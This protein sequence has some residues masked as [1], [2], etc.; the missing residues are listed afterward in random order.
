MRS[1]CVRAVAC[2][3]ALILGSLG[4]TTYAATNRCSGPITLG[5]TISETGAFSSQT[6][7]WKQMTLAFQKAINRKGGVEVKACHKK[8]PIK[9]VVYNDQS[10]ASTAVSLFEKMATGGHVDFFVGPDWSAIGGP[11]STVAQKHH[12][13]IVMANVSTPSIY[14]RGFKWVFGTPYPEVKLWSKRYFDML[15][16]MTPKPKTIFFVTEDNPVTKAIT[17]VWSKRAAKMGLK[18]VGKE[19][20]QPGLKDFTSL[21]LRMKAAHPDVIYIS[22]FDAA[23]APLIQAMRQFQVKALDVHHIMATARLSAEVGKDLNGVTGELPWF[24]GVGGPHSKLVSQV[25]KASH[26]SMYRDIFTMARLASYLVMV[27]AIQKA[28]SLDR[29][30][31][32]SALAHDTFHMPPGPIKFN[33][34]GY[35]ENNGAFTIQIQHGKVVVVWPR[36]RATG[37]VLW[38]APSWR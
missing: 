12:I 13:P 17:A 15:T 33:K 28:G 38:P 32:R 4:L 3:T 25:L 16:H 18:V 35:P 29:A 34:D 31:V 23:S 5:T 27:E 11:V 6:A 9:F 26:V 8:L 37:K 21:V 1:D 14:K 30:K 20:F 7:H 36:S 2:V 24:P 19:K 10:N 22:S